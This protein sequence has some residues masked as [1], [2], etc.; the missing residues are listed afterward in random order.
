MS[1]GIVK[2]AFR[3]ARS[4]DLVSRAI[5]FCKIIDGGEKRKHL[6]LQ[7]ISKLALLVTN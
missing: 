4:I 3:G 1:T 2:K 5:E 7:N 6:K